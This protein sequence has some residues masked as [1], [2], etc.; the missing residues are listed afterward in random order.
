MRAIGRADLL[1]LDDWGLDSRDAAAVQEFRHRWTL[2][3]RKCKCQAI[4][5][6]HTVDFFGRGETGLDYGNQLPQRH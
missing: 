1:I 4:V 3:L 2:S 6:N 5:A